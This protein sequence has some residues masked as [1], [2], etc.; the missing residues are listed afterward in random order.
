MTRSRIR[1]MRKKGNFGYYI[2]SQVRYYYDIAI[3]IDDYYLQHE[4]VDYGFIMLRIMNNAVA[5]HT[6]QLRYS[7]PPPECLLKEK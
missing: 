7:L 6:T 5:G 2:F 3:C 4:L 1:R